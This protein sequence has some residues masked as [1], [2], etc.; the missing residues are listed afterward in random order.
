M[1]AFITNTIPIYWGD[2][3]AIKDFNPDAFINCHNF[4]NF[5]EVV[6]FVK[7]VD[8]DEKLYLEILNAPAFPNNEIPKHLKMGKSNWI[9]Q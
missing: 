5:S 1:H 4:N 3:H 8:Q 6:E 7:Q 2:P 9:F